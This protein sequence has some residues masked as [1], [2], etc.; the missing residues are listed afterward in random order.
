MTW[1]ESGCTVTARL[2]WICCW[3]FESPFDDWCEPSLLKTKIINENFEKKINNFTFQ[4]LFQLNDIEHEMQ[5]DEH[6]KLVLGL[7]PSVYIWH[8]YDKVDKLMLEVHQQK[9]YYHPKAHDNVRDEMYLEYQHV[10]I[11]KN[12]IPL[13]VLLQHQRLYPVEYYRFFRTKK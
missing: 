9:N 5:Q 13:D 2:N 3:P 7:I 1:A 6:N 10:N 4:V 11:N 12:Q 8:M